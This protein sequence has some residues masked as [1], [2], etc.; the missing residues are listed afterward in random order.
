MGPSGSGKS[1][2]L[3]C[4]AGLL[5]PDAGGVEV[6][7]VRL[8]SLSDR[9]RSRLRL[10]RFGFVPQFGDLVPELTLR[11]NVELPLRLLGRGR[12]ESRARAAELLERLGVADIADHRAGEAS[13]GQVQ[14]TAAARALAHEPAV[15]LADEPTGSL[16]TVSGEQVLDAFL[17][18]AR[19]RGTAVIVVTHEHAVAAH[20]DREVVMRD[21]RLRDDSLAGA[22]A[23]GDH[24][25][26]TRR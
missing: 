3:H 24:E 19:D 15:L 23:A 17:D 13:G 12:R 7:G 20:A 6:D 18:Q 11:E 9:Q 5:R 1:T 10:E 4:L 2:L 25:R 8:D 16:D 26:L 14:R 22:A 21:G